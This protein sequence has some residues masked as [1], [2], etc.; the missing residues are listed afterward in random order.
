LNT[1]R[2]EVKQKA[3]WIRS[4]EFLAQ[5]RASALA[6]CAGYWIFFTLLF[7]DTAAESGE[8][9]AAALRMGTG[10]MP[11][12][13]LLHALTSWTLVLPFGSPGGNLVVFNGLIMGLALYHFVRL[14][15]EILDDPLSSLLPPL[16]MVAG[17]LFF[18]NTFFFSPIPMTFLCVVVL[19]RLLEWPLAD[20]RRLWAA[21]FILGLGFVGVHPVF[22]L[23]LVPF[24]AYLLWMFAVNRTAVLTTP[25]FWLAGA[26]ISIH[27]PLTAHRFAPA[28]ADGTVLSGWMHTL[29]MRPELELA[30]PRIASVHSFVWF[31]DLM[32]QLEHLGDSIPVILLPLVIVGLWPR[33]RQNKFYVLLGLGLAEWA[34]AVWMMPGSLG[35]AQTG[36]LFSA[37]LWI[38]CARGVQLVSRRL[39]EPMARTGFVIFFLLAGTLATWLSDGGERFHLE[40]PNPRWALETAATLPPGTTLRVPG[41]QWSQWQAAMALLRHHPADLRMIVAGRGPLAVE[42]GELWSPLLSDRLPDRWGLDP[43]SPLAGRPVLRADLPDPSPQRLDSLARALLSPVGRQPSFVRWQTARVLCA[44]G[45]VFLHNGWLSAAARF[46]SLARAVSPDLGAVVLL[47]AR[48]ES[49]W[50]RHE[51]ARMLLKRALSADGSDPRV[52]ARLARADRELALSGR[53]PPERKRPLLDEGLDSVRRALILDPGR[54]AYLELAAAIARDLEMP[55]LAEQYERMMNK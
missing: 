44:W 28:L 37:A 1:N 42:P 24:L 53:T 4:V 15:Q 31:P 23:L 10:P 43:V 26:A 12:Y 7:H 17:I 33:E 32:H 39:D 36:W 55:E 49:A 18:R 25:M 6:I 41:Q 38:S 48:L 54:E 50:F 52:H 5:P 8:L 13:S 27:I 2:E 30:G 3:I 20:A 51:N 29:S 11:G 45:E 46:Q 14:S 35:L 21:A 40:A 9:A 22:R 19:L 47:Q 34:W 16:G